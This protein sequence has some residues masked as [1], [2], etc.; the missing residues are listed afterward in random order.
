MRRVN[1]VAAVAVLLL[2]PAAVL[3]ESYWTYTSKDLD[4]VTTVGTAGDVHALE[5]ARDLARFDKVVASI[6]GIPVRHAPTRIYE[7]APEQ[8]KNLLGHEGANSY[9]FS[10]YEVTVVAD[11]EA[12]EHERDWGALFGYM[13]SLV[14]SGPYAHYPVW[15]RNGI[16]TLFAHTEFKGGRV[17]T[18]GVDNQWARPVVSSNLIPMRVFLRLKAGDPQLRGAQSNV[19]F[20]E[21][22]FLAHEI[23]VESKLRSQFGQYLDLMQHGKSEEDAFA[24]SFKMSYEDLE[25]LLQRSLNDQVHVLVVDAPYE[26]PESGQVLQLST[27]ETQARLADLSLQW[28]HNAEALRLASAVLQQDPANELALRTLAR[29]SLQAGDAPAARSAVE[30]LSA[31]PALS[32]A[33]LTDVGDVTAD[34]GERLSKQAAAPGDAASLRGRAQA[35]YERALSLDSEYLRAWAGLARLYGAPTDSSA[36]QALVQRAAPVM[37]RHSDSRM[38]AQ[39]CHDVRPHRTD[40]FRAALRRILAQRRYQRRRS[41]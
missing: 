14:V 5:L 4:V 23:F 3:A 13:G 19:F 15:F 39:A 21:S 20:A 24:A 28:K 41:R 12:R 2:S 34:L 35:A 16:V 17:M 25:K 22:W 30:K 40:R 36:A 9:R 18:G 10:G 33:A 11:S 31:L 8:V 6:L 32:A 37:E 27:A 38:L 7:L 1:I 26:A 29:V